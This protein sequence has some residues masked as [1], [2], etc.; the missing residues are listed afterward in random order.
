MKKVQLN[1]L[2]DNRVNESGEKFIYKGLYNSSN[3]LYFVYNSERP[4]QILALTESEVEN[5]N[6]DIKENPI[7]MGKKYTLVEHFGVSTIHLK[8]ARLC[9]KEYEA[10]ERELKAKAFDL[11][12]DELVSEVIELDK[13][14]I[15]YKNAL[16]DIDSLTYI[17]SGIREEFKALVKE[18]DQDF[19][20]EES[21]LLPSL[22]EY[23]SVLFDGADKRLKLNGNTLYLYLTLF[24]PFRTLQKAMKRVDEEVVNGLFSR[25]CP[26]YKGDN[27]N[28]VNYKLKTVLTDKYTMEQAE[29]LN[30]EIKL[31]ISLLSDVIVK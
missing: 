12:L 1:L 8:R 5:V 19:E 16:V 13:S 26:I 24:G 2:K 25:S 29:S 17:L 4:S 14:T 30:K 23:L 11:T 3:D 20:N 6:F 15:F 10:K 9:K 18:E 21:S 7:L 27:P 28:V 31:I 22:S